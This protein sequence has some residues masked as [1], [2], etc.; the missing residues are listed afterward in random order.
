MVYPKTKLMFTGGLQTLM[1]SYDFSFNKVKE[2]I[3]AN[4]L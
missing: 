3:T 2:K 4:E 1:I